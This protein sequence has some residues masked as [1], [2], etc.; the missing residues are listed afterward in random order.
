VRNEIQLGSGFG[1]TAG[2]DFFCLK[3]IIGREG[4]SE[5]IENKANGSNNDM[6]PKDLFTLL[7]LPMSGTNDRF[8]GPLLKK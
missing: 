3:D 5:R 8:K 4:E 1:L 7:V 2:A 6:S